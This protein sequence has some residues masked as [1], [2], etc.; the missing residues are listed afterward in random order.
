MRIRAWTACMAIVAVSA[1]AGAASASAATITFNAPIDGPVFNECTGETIVIDGTAHFK[2]TDNSS[3]DGTKSHIEMNF[4][5]KGIALMTGA[6]Y[7]MNSQ[8]S[9]VQH[10]EFD[11]KGD[12]QLTMEETTIF[13]RQGETGELLVGDDFRLHVIIH[14]TVTNGVTKASKVELRADCR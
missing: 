11:P 10:A 13:N 14:L 8:Y 4:S 5:G 6:Q 2:A 9:D 1:G 3:S 12:A 7:V